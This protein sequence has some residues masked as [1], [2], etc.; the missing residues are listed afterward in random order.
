M[1]P[2]KITIKT[3]GVLSESVYIF[4][5][6]VFF[7]QDSKFPIIV[8]PRAPLLDKWHIRNDVNVMVNFKPGK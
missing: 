6:A 3:F 7:H 1:Q 8:M 2:L 4:S 5:F